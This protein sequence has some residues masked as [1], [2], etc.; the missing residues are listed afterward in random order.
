MK[1]R[2]YYAFD[3]PINKNILC[4]NRES[5]ASPL[6]VNCAG[7]MEGLFSFTTHNVT[8][9]E[10]YYLM[11]IASGS[12]MV[13]FPEKRICAFAGSVLLF[14]PH[15]PYRY[16]YEA[17]KEPLHYYW[18]HFTG[19]HASRYLEEFGLSPSPCLREIGEEN[20]IQNRFLSLF[21]HFGTEDP[22]RDHALGCSLHQLLISLAHAMQDKSVKSP[23]AKSLRYINEKFT[24]DIRIPDLAQME[25]LSISRY[26]VLFQRQTGTSPIRYITKLRMDNAC[27]LLRSTNLSVKQIGLLVGYEDPH[28]FSKLFKR[29]LGCSPLLYRKQL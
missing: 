4:C 22:F 17:K 9:R 19:S 18:V 15:Y 21:D 12:L 5:D 29:Y 1:T 8:G 20:H 14:P 23:I 13:D 16:T 3:D 24:S 7:T 2:G 25:N 26:S 27:V 6:I 28:F 10:D 11:Y